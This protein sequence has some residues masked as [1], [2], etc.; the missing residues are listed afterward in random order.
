MD[1]PAA[2]LSD[3]VVDW[4]ASPATINNHQDPH[5]T[6]E[7]GTNSNYS[8][9]TTTDISQTQPNNKQQQYKRNVSTYSIDIPATMG[10]IVTNGDGNSRSTTSST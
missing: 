8:K 7:A 10:L 4:R 6:S 5:H 3:D 9:G 2:V 1:N